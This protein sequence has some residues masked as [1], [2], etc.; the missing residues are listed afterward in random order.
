[1]RVPAIL[2]P[3]LV[4]ACA[5]ERA[6]APAG[7]IPPARTAG[8]SAPGDLDASRSTRASS[9]ADVLSPTESDADEEDQVDF[10]AT[11][12][13]NHA[14]RYRARFVPGYANLLEFV[15]E[16]TGSGWQEKF[17]LGVPPVP[18]SGP[19]PL[20]VVFHKYGVGHGDVLNT[21]FLTEAANRGW[22]CV[23]PLGA[24]QRHFG[25]SES[26]INTRAAL[27]LVAQ[28]F[29]IDRNRVYGV[30]F[31]MGGGAV[32]NYAARH[33][34]PAGI[35][36][37][38]ICEHTGTVSLTHTWFWEPDDNDVDDNTPLAGDNLEVPDVLEARFGGP[39]SLRAFEYQRCST[40][41]LDPFTGAVGAGTDFARNLAHIPTLTWIANS[42]PMVY[43][44]TQTYAFDA[45]VRAQNAANALTVVSGN[46]HAWTTLNGQAVCDWLQQFTLQA[47]T[48]G[49]TLADEDGVWLRFH[50]QQDAPGAFTPFTWSVDAGT[51]TIVISQTANLRVLTIDAPAFGVTPVACSITLRVS[52]A[53]GTGDRIRLLGVAS[54]P[55][56]VLRDGQASSGT[57]DALTQ[58][59]EIVE[60]D[61]AQ[62]EWVLV[63][64]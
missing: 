27:D 58:S 35:Q 8:P 54:A 34:D 14:I 31:S 2:L 18:P 13:N 32:A 24:R 4:C 20:L 33:L 30:G 26:Q 40:I 1:M 49:S 29:P 16:N 64:P 38:A 50:V 7:G 56:Q 55:N 47:P 10:A 37:A 48:S 62:H 12:A 21:T 45:H 6:L 25:N 41:D 23:A 57:Y 17:L 19:V 52:S 36:F 51:R 61:P 43:L 46:T 59:F 9:M 39:P 11:V 22:Y 3:L 42:D 53:D 63:F 28:I 15:L 44:G 60:S 5:E